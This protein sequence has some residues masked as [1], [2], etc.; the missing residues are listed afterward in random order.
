MA[1]AALIVELVFSTLGLVPPQYDATASKSN[2]RWLRVPATKFDT[3]NPAIS[4]DCWV[5]VFKVGLSPQQNQWLSFVGSNH[6]RPIAV[7]I[8]TVG[9]RR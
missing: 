9:E 8:T 7:G 1:G 6:P 3:R 5:F 2:L 4:M